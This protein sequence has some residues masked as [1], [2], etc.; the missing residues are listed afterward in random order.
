MLAYKGPSLTG[1]QSPGLN[2]E[3]APQSEWRGRPGKLLTSGKDGHTYLE[4]ASAYRGNM[5]GMHWF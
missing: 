2:G 4:K 5:N 3:A 1:R